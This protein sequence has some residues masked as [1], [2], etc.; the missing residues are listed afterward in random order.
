MVQFARRQIDNFLR[1]TFD[2]R[3]AR[4][5]GGSHQGV[6]VGDVEG[7]SHQSHA[8]GPVQAFGE[9]GAHLGHAVPV[10]VA[11]QHDA[12][13]AGL[14]R[15]GI[16]L[17]PLGDAVHQAFRGLGFRTGFGDQHVAVRKNQQPARVGQISGEARDDKPLRRHRGRAFGPADRLGRVHP[18]QKI[19]FRGRDIR[20]SAKADEW[21]FRT[22]LTGGEQKTGCDDE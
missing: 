20:I 10:G 18:G 3:L 1:L 15:A 9:D 13:G 8:L 7:L 14:Q 11:Q 5:P 4:T 12:V 6:G 21:F 2:L 19:V 17:H 16:A 22:G